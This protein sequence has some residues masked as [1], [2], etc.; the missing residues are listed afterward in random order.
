MRV[1]DDAAAVVL[2]H[3][4]LVE[5]EPV[6]VGHAA[7]RDQHDIGF[8]RFGRAALGRLDLGLQRRAR[9]IDA[10]DLGAELEGDALLF[11][12][13]LRLP[14]D[15]VVEARQDAVEE[16]DHRHLRAEPPPHRAELEPDH[17]GADHQQPLRHLVERDRL[18]RG[19]DALAVDVDALELRHIGAGG[20]DDVLGLQRL[21]LAVGALDLDLARRGDAAGAVHRIDLVLLE[22]VIDALDVAVDALV[23]ELH[24]RGEIE[25]RRADADAHLAQS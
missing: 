11:Q 13:A 22:Q 17:A 6:G 20:D 5:A 14:A 10:G 15:L 25:L 2:L 8:D 1:D 4:G 19:D 23:L 7:D 9:R 12:D 21:R 3:A 18:I 24:Q 16:F